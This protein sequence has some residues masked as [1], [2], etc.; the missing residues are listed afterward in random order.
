MQLERYSEVNWAYQLH[1]YVCFQTHKRH[2]TFVS[3]ERTAHLQRVFGEICEC[4]EYHLLQSKLYPDQ[5]RCLISLR[6]EQAIA[7]VVQKIKGNL[8]R[9]YGL[10]FSAPSPLWARGY[11]ARSV[12]RVRVERVKRYLENQPEHHGY[13]KRVLPPVFRY[14]AKMIPSL[15]AVHAVFDLTH[16]LVFATRYRAGVFNSAM[17]EALTKYWL[18]VANRR[19]FAIGQVSILPDHIHLMI[20][21]VPKMSVEDCALALM[22]NGQYFCGKHFS[23]ML[24]HTG[25]ERLWQPSAYAGTCGEM[26]TALLKSFLSRV[27]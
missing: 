1:Y 21:T 19:G 13:H 9:E 3:A 24:V 12:G 27:D 18:R 15:A 26:T 11:L 16:H 4:H 7:T 5:I 23:S 22:N 10:S 20:K 8:S 6:P 14:R 2:L 17:A 25:V